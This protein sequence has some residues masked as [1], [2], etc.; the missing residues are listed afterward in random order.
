MEKANWKLDDIISLKDFDALYAKTQQGITEYA[1]IFEKLSADM[2]EEDFIEYTKFHEELIEN[3]HKLGSRPALMEAADQKD[4]LALKLKNKVKDLEIKFSEA[5][6]PIS[7]WLKGKE[8][9]G[10]EVL[11]DANA[12]RL[13]ASTPELEYVYSYSR[14]MG[15]YSLDE[16]SENIM[17]AK[18]ANGV[19]V[20]T[21][22]RDMIET[23]FEYDFNPE[24]GERKIIKNNA[25]ISAYAYSTNPKER[26]AAFEARF[27]QYKKNIDKFF[28]AYQAI[29]KDWNYEAK[30]RGFESSIAVRNTANHVDDKSISTLMEVCSNNVGIFQDYFKFKARELGLNKLTRFDLYAPLGEINEEYS[31]DEAIKLV[32]DSFRGFS[33]RFADNALKII[34]ENHIDS[35]PTD[36]KRGGAFC[37]TISPSITPYVLLNYTGKMRDVSTLAHELGHG[38][39]SL[40][41]NKHSISTQHATLPLAETASTLGEMI[42]FEKILA[43]TKDNETKKQLLS[44]KLADSYATVARQNFIVKFEIAAHE[45]IQRGI[46]E[47]ELSQLWLDNLKEQFGDSVEV[48]DMFRYEWAYIPHIVHTPF[49]CYAYNFGE[50]LSMALYAKYKQEGESFV[51]KIEE[52]LAAG[53]SEDPKLILEKVGIDMS[54]ADFWQGSFELIKAWQSELEKL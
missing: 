7:L 3:I 33:G 41:A 16:K 49:Y 2:P 44:D 30:A 11:D 34:N 37:M 6:Q 14:M 54:S 46:E 32:D 17:T 51:P 42:L 1:K 31:Y 21:D 12:K 19:R 47:S 5:V 24:G 26:K 52:I 53:G 36:T 25:E 38:V 9:Q 48:D 8:V 22:L 15:K 50:L 18:D 43:N 13:F 23:E 28:V 45:A 4:S 39:H 20:V 10:K 40:Y 29:V 35:H 27:D